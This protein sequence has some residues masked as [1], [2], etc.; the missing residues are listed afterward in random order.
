[1]SDGDTLV[2]ALLDPAA[3][4]HPVDD[5]RMLETHISWVF[6]TGEYAYKIKKPVV[7]TF[8]DFSA[9]EMRKHWCGEEIRLNSRWAPQLY[10]DVVPIS[11]SADAPEVGGGG[12]PIEYAVRMRQF[13]QSALLSE[14][15]AAGRIDADD[16]I[17][18]ADMIADRHANLP[19]HREARFGSPAAITKPMHENFV[20]I[21]PVLEEPTLSELKDWTDA[22][23]DRCSAAIDS[24]WREGFLRACHGDLHLRNLVHLEDGIVA[25]DCVEFSDELRILDVISDIG[26][27]TMDL[28]ANDRADLART[29]IN[30]YLE[31]SGDYGGMRLYG[32][33]YVYHCLIRAKVDAIRAAARVPG[34]E[35]QRDAFLDSMRH[36]CRVAM[37]WIHRPR[38]ALIVMHGFSGSGKTWVSSRLLQSLYAVRIRSDI[39]RKRLY[40]IG[41]RASSSS[42][43]GE[44]L[45]GT[46]ESAATH[47]HMLDIARQLLNSGHRVI[48]D[49]S[50]L[51]SE[52]RKRARSLAGEKG[53]PFVLVDVDAASD[54]LERRIESRQAENKDASEAN[55][56]VLEHQRRHSD[57]LDDETDGPVVRY[58][59]R[60]DGDLDELART[61]G[62]IIE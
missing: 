20:Y 6:L 48:L 12:T 52:E 5:L 35:Q 3:W 28:V 40:G 23:L 18:L 2:Q 59:C 46:D 53:V 50:F 1:M 14:R 51:R 43:P 36:Y 49:A 13:P 58:E 32:M 54:V 60:D 55:L 22:E 29:V 16:M 47:D 45:Y 21:E 33:Y 38:P 15:L 7:L 42:A 56:D 27:L 31:V 25:F 34:E 39:E 4:P 24:R 19:V 9:L 61:I 8:L 11:G 26:F 37:N 41:E 57:P 10:I 17:E 44:G 30:R 62:S